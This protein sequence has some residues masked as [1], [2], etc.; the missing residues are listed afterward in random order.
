M[1]DIVKVGDEVSVVVLSI[2]KAQRRMS[3]SIKAAQGKAAA[4]EE[5]AETEE[6]A[7]PAKPPRPRTTPCAEAP[8]TA[9]SRYL[10]KCPSLISSNFSNS[11]PRGDTFRILPRRFP[12]KL[13]RLI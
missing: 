1:S 7:T 2:D 3:L 4:V 11:Q 8:G 12:P 13:R 6:P 10:D 9:T 5:E